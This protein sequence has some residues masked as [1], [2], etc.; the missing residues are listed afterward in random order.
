M[1]TCIVS[2]NPLLDEAREVG[3]V[4]LLVVILKLFH[5]VT[6][7]AAI[8]AVSKSV[9]FQLSTLGVITNESLRTER[10][11]DGG[12]EREGGREGGGGVNGGEGKE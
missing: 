2:R 8:D 1:I 3:F 6:D 10:K 11:E 9:C 4:F 5:V 12:G 7:M